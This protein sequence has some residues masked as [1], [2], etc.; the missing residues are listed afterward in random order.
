MAAAC[1][2]ALGEERLAWMRGLPLKQ[3]HASMVLVH[4]SP[5][6]PWRAPAPEAG[7]AELE[8]IYGPLGG[9]VAV[10]GHIH[11]GYL[12][13]LPGMTVVNAGSVS[14][15]YDGDPR[16]SYVLLDDTVPLLRRVEYDVARE[17]RAIR[18]AALPYADWLAKML[19]TA[20]PQMP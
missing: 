8:A 14:L 4:A 15:S 3:E 11:R 12:R 7:D 6:S 18:A 19:E 16:A 1:R 13:G 9:A 2:A 5:S 17:V 10:Y 20:R